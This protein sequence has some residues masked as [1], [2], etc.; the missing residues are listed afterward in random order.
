MRKALLAAAAVLA[1]LA[2]C[3]GLPAPDHP[4]MEDPGEDQIGWE[5]GYWYD[6]SIAVTPGDGL[7]ESEQAALLARTKARVEQLRDQEFRGNV[8]LEVIT[9]A[10]YRNRST[11]GSGV[12]QENPWNDQVWEAL[13]LVGEN[14]TSGEALGGTRNS[15]VQGYYAPANDSIVIV[16][17]SETPT[18]DRATLAH[19]LVHA[20]QDQ[21]GRLNATPET[22]DQQLARQSVTEGEANYVR[23]L[24]EQRC[25]DGWRCVERPQADGGDASG[26]SPE[27]GVFVTIYQPYAT[28]PRFVHQIRQDGGW[29]AVDGLYEDVPNSTEQV[30]H[31]DK[32]PEEDPVGVTVPDRSGASWERFDH[33]PVADTVGE[34][35]IFAMLYDHGAVSPEEW[36]RYRANA[37]AGWAGDSVVPYRNESGAGAYVWRTEWDT[38]RD[39]REFRDAYTSILE[40]RAGSQPRDGVYRLPESDPFGD[41]FRVRRSGQTVT[42]VNAPTVDRLDDV[43]RAR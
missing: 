41:A 19:E 2:G 20:L 13:L 26:G 24:Y 36:Y 34:A 39:A 40:E 17:D 28:G 31:P 42:I 43:H 5:G 10:E 27:D 7:N 35:S 29:D 23:I 22:Q 6:E 21:R 12:R 30:I 4:L 14:S 38:E 1:L 9:R 3:S 25:G 15:S 18:V 16:S 8:S 33:D 11:G 37:S 32:Y